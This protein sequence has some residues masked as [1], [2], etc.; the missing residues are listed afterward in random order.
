MDTWTNASAGAVTI[1]IALVPLPCCSISGGQGWMLF[2]SSWFESL[3]VRVGGRI[4]MHAPDVQHNSRPFR[5]E[6]TVNVVVLGYRMGNPQWTDRSPAMCF[7]DNAVNIW[8]LG[9]I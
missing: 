7:F 2:E 5:E 4:V 8:Q 9:E 6:H 1:M 3:W